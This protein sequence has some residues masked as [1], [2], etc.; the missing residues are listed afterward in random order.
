VRREGCT[1]VQGF[2]FSRPLPPPEASAYI[3]G[4]ADRSGASRGPRVAATRG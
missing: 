1:Q 4:R 3:A 2:L